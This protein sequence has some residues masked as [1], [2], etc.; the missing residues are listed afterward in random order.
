[1]EARDGEPTSNSQR[2]RGTPQTRLH[3]N[4]PPPDGHQSRREDT[5]QFRT[6]MRNVISHLCVACLPLTG[7]QVSV[8][9]RH[10]AQNGYGLV[11]SVSISPRSVLNH[12]AQCCARAA[13]R[14]PERTKKSAA[15]GNSGG[16]VDVMKGAGG[17]YRAGFL[18]G[19]GGY[20]GV[21]GNVAHKCAN[22]VCTSLLE[23]CS[24]H[25]WFAMIPPA[26]LAASVRV[27]GYRGGTS[28]H[29]II[30]RWAQEQIYQQQCRILPTGVLELY[31]SRICN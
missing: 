6:Y 8:L 18:M 20:R 12:P 31:P 11:L 29:S 23:K 10:N 4:D 14:L 15:S 13:A 1:M 22:N 16:V 26:C 2:P 28:K 21:S 17:G 7:H 9:T 27:E 3:C 5:Q 25:Q 19:I 30:L 24:G